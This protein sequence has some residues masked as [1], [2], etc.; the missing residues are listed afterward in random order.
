MDFL[1]KCRERMKQECERKENEED[2]CTSDNMFAAR[3]IFPW[4]PSLNMVQY[5]C[6]GTSVRLSYM[7]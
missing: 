4:F 6:C 3:P 1:A 7:Y 2:F 5:V